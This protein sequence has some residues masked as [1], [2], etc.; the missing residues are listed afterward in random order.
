[1]IIKTIRDEDFTNYKEACMLIG[2]PRCSFKCEKE[3]GRKMC[4]NSSMATSPDIE[5]SLEQIVRRYLDN[6]ITSSIV[7][8]G[9]EPFDTWIDMIAL[10]SVFRKHTE[11]TII[12][13]TGYNR[14]EILPQVQWLEAN[15]KNIIVK[16]GRFI[17]D[18]LKHPDA[19]LGIDLASDNQY[20]ERIC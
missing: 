16:F 4:Q 3:C 13:Y 1:M 20:A 12:I 15:C 8:G 14:E 5:I 11:D 10:I 2:F 7:F 9:L 19:V 17:P 18:Q 6:P